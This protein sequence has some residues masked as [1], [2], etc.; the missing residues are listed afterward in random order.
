MK[1]LSYVGHREKVRRSQLQI[2]KSA[3]PLDFVETVMS[4]LQSDRAAHSENVDGERSQ[5]R[6]A[7]EEETDQTRLLIFAWS[8]WLIRGTINSRDIVRSRGMCAI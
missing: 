6:E 3:F 8:G 4:L 5:R 7:V 2:E 1:I